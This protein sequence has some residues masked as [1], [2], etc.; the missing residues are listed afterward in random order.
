MCGYVFLKFFKNR[1]GT[2]EESAAEA[3]RQCV[4][5]SGVSF[6]FSFLFF[7]FLFFS[8]LFFSFLFFSFLFFSFLFFSF[9]FFS[10]L[11]FSNFSPLRSGSIFQTTPSSFLELPLPCSLPFFSSLSLLDFNLFSFIFIF[12]LNR[13][14]LLFLLS[15]GAN[16]IAID[17]NF[18]HVWKRLIG[19]FV[20]SFFFNLFSFNFFFF[21]NFSGPRTPVGL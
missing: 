14:P 6:F 11:F 4:K 12:F 15:H 18:P 17:I 7:S 16:I 1:Y 10:F 2:I 13:G 9:L 19:L 3:I 21:F 5:N 20:F 8:F